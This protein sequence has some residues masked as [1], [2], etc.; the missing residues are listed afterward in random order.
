MKKYLFLFVLVV[1][2]S[3]GLMAQRRSAGTHLF[4]ENVGQVFSSQ[5]EKANDVLFTYSRQGTSLFFRKGGYSIVQQ[6]RDSFSRSTS[7]SRTDIE[8]T[9]NRD[10]VPLADGA[11]INTQTLYKGADVFRAQEFS[12]I[13]YRNLLSGVD[14]HFMIDANGQLLQCMTTNEASVDVP[15][16]IRC[17]WNTGDATGSF[18]LGNNAG[19]VL[20]SGLMMQTNDIRRCYVPSRV[21]QYCRNGIPNTEDILA[22]QFIT[23]VGGSDADDFWDIQRCA[24]GDFVV[25][26][27]SASANFPVSVGAFQDSLNASYDAIVARV[28]ATGNRVWASY[29]GSNGSDIANHLILLDDAIYVCG[30]TNGTDFP[31]ANAWQQT[32]GGSYDAFLLKMDSAGNRIW[33]TYFGGSVGENGIDLVA[34][35]QANIYLGGASSSQNLPLANLGWQPTNGGANDMFL[36]KFDST[37][38]PHWSTYYGGSGTEDIHAVA[39]GPN[40]EI[41][42][43]GGTHS[44]NFPVSA[45]AWQSGSTGL[46][47]I[48]MAIFDTAGNRLYASYYGGFNA[49][50]AYGLEVDALG[51][52]YI[53]GM[54]FSVDF[55][56]TGTIFQNMLAGQNDVCVMRLSPTG[57]PEWSTFVGGGS[58]DFTYD[59]H[60]AG[61]YMYICGHTASV[62]F[63]IA[64]PSFQDSIGGTTDAFQFKMDTAGHMIC[65]TFLGGAF[66][67]SGNGIVIDADTNAVIAGSTSSIGLPATSGV[68]QTMYGG[69]G[70]GFIAVVDASCQLLPND[71][72]E[73]V[74]VSSNS[75]LVAN[76]VSDY[77]HIQLPNGI[78]VRNTWVYD[79]SGRKCMQ[80]TQAQFSVDELRAGVYVVW[81]EDVNGVWYQ[82]LFVVG[83]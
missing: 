32:I 53:A 43:C 58:T 14:L 75:I 72:T 64:A 76:L 15:P 80:G 52:I 39:I 81:V 56:T 9:T 83:E 37:G 79:M 12:S 50:D 54:T 82:E 11:S 78:G 10:V 40:N 38:V 35:G 48:Y 70:D 18:S 57:V 20:P 28:D 71:V 65:G 1:V 24:N 22:I 4:V 55:P 66:F 17:R 2:S 74:D 60:L 31:V 8:F 26:G 27:N 19:I 67:D 7:T 63:P 21:Y 5:K 73:Q 68:W 33:C 62:D 16:L 47:D 13:V 29:F 3:N 69:L 30:Q 46:P 49:E 51:K 25:V 34:D 41:V 6:V 42:A 23:F 45:N 59:M 36:A 44:M 61:K 77:L